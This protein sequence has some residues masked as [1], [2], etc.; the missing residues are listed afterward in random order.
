MG[1]IFDIQIDVKQKTEYMSYWI[2]FYTKNLFF[3]I[4]FVGGLKNVNNSYT[5]IYS[6]AQ[7]LLLC[8]IK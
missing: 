5:I 6:K 2:T 8:V 1:C 4:N 3:C 7:K